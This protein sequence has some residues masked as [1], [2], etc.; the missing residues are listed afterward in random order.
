MFWTETPSLT[1]PIF[2]R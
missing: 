1:N 2:I